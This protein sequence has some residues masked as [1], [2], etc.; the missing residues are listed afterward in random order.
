MFANNHAIICL[1][2]NE[3]KRNSFIKQ[4]KPRL[5]SSFTRY[6]R[7][8]N[9]FES[10]NHLSSL[11]SIGNTVFILSLWLLILTHLKQFFLSWAILFKLISP[12]NYR[13]INFILSLISL[14]YIETNNKTTLSLSLCLFVFLFFV[15]TGPHICREK[16]SRV[17]GVGKRWMWQRAND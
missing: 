15:W 6:S 1:R 2:I 11:P 17:V 3:Q 10:N 4:T 14:L 9:F 7:I 16:G 13:V 5:S 8:Y 12:K